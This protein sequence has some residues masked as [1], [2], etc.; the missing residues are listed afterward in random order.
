M[1]AS[2]TSH[3]LD[4]WQDRF[5][6]KVIGGRRRAKIRSI[7]PRDS[8]F[9]EMDHVAFMDG[10]GEQFVFQVFVFVFSSVG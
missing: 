4:T 9:T 7:E 1:E 8:R 5:L 2:A 3:I 6:E 10:H